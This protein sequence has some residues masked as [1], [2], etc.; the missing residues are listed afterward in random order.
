[1]FSKFL[2]NLSGIKSRN[3]RKNIYEN[4]FLDANILTDNSTKP[5][6]QSKKMRK[7]DC[8][9]Q[10]PD[11]NFFTLPESRNPKFTIPESRNPKYGIMHGY[12]END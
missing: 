7:S 11:P 3:K 6:S 4:W 2:N 12:S 5:V 8:F 10:A 1:M 9:M